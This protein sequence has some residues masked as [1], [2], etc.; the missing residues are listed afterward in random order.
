M[1][2]PGHYDDREVQLTVANDKRAKLFWSRW[3]RTQTEDAERRPV[4]AAPGGSKRRRLPWLALGSLPVDH[5]EGVVKLTL[6]SDRLH[7]PCPRY[8]A[9]DLAMG[10]DVSLFAHLRSVHTIS[11][12]PDGKPGVSSSR[13]AQDRAAPLS[14]AL[15]LHRIRRLLFGSSPLVVAGC[16]GVDRIQRPDA[17]HTFRDN[18]IR[19]SL[20]ADSSFLVPGAAKHLLSAV[21]LHREVS[22]LLSHTTLA[23]D[24]PAGRAPSMAVESHFGKRFLG[25]LEH[26]VVIDRRAAPVPLMYCEP[27][28]GWGLSCRT[29][30]SCPLS[31]GAMTPY[32]KSWLKHQ[33]WQPFFFQRADNV[34][35]RFSDV[36]IGLETEIGCVLPLALQ[37][38]LP[39]QGA[40]DRFEHGLPLDDRLLVG[41]KF[42]GVR[43]N[44]LGP[45]PLVEG[46]HDMVGGSLVMGVT[47]RVSAAV[48]G[49]LQDFGF[50]FHAFGS[51]LA[52]TS[53]SHLLHLG[54]EMRLLCGTGLMFPSPFG[55]VEINM[56]FPLKASWRA[57][58]LWTSFQI[59]IGLG[60]LDRHA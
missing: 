46:R 3:L 48:P 59:S 40:W 58:D 36:S 47:G 22:P 30:L 53:L 1:G 8:V 42:R 7:Q 49:R 14:E 51:C 52:N 12:L 17:S 60:S 38:L 20:A 4:V 28:R 43:T 57:T 50:R 33:I 34:A 44:G 13:H 6:S 24:E 54:R 26:E 19:A 9:V 41:N 18:F 10:S 45:R 31:G 25:Y 35:G 55:A 39:R 29:T 11:E 15:S 21:F 56:C 2:H 5:G 27:D 16:V 23:A 37:L 32:L